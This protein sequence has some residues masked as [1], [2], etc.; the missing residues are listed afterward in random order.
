MRTGDRRLEY[1]ARFESGAL[2]FLSFPPFSMPSL[3]KLSLAGTTL[4]LA[5]CAT[6]T[7]DPGPDDGSG[8]NPSTGGGSGLGGETA[9][10]GV[11]GAG[12]TGN[13][14]GS[15]ATGGAG[16]G[17]AGTGGA[18]TGGAGTGGAATGG[19]GTGGAAGD[20]TAVVCGT[21]P[22]P[23]PSSA[24]TCFAV[25]FGQYGGW[26]VSNATG[27]TFTLNGETA[28][29]G[30][31]PPQGAVEIGFAGCSSADVSWSCWQ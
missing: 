12:A 28:T 3:I 9:T 11:I 14:G 4:L 10:G 20:C 29:A 31:T 17:G 15:P 21:G 19:A 18:A 23:K 22:Y 6:I 25:T 8:G 26:Q 24:E 1:A 7:N 5:A 13:T 2:S 16:T 30:Q 27:C